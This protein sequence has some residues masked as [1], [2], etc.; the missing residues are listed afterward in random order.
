[1]IDRQKI[2]RFDEVSL[3]GRPPRDAWLRRS[4]FVALCVLMI[5]VANVP[6]TLASFGFENDKLNHALA[7]AVMTQL[8]T[9]K[10]RLFSA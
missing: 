4:V 2:T 5:V 10:N 3:P 8:D 1:M 9:S 7:L 6:P